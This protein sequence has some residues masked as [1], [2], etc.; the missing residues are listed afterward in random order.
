MKYKVAVI[1]YGYWGP[2]LTRNFNNSNNFEIKYIVDLS[3][4]N[5]NKAKKNFP[6]S[7][8]LKNYKDLSK[9]KLD[10]VVVASSTQSHYKI[11]KYLLDFTNVLV[12]KPLCLSV[13]QVSN[14]EKKAKKNDKLLFVDYPFIF[15]GSVSFLSKVIKKNSFGK[16]NEIESYREQAPIRNDMDVIW[17]G[18]NMINSLSREI[19][20]YE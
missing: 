2:K 5:L 7:K 3:D 10:L 13:K 8:I 1:G 15:S 18:Y 17:D 14:L 19:P 12:E 16:L 9:K 6:I 4:A 11:S 20:I